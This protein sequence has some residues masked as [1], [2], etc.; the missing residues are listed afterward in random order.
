MNLKCPKCGSEGTQKLT[1]VMDKGGTLEKA[2]KMQVSYGVNI[3][4][5]VA[6]VFIAFLV[7]LIF[8]WNLLIAAIVFVAIIYGGFAWR[9]KIKAKAKGKYDDLAP[10]MKQ[11]GFLCNRCENLFIPA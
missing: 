7:S 5:P 2:A 3:A 10:D 6:T 11:N 4:M 1:L 9:K 8:I